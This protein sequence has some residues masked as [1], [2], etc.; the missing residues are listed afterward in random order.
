M[1]LSSSF[2]PLSFPFKPIL[3]RSLAKSG[4]D[5]AMRKEVASIGDSI[6]AKSNQSPPPRRSSLLHESCFSF[7]DKWDSTLPYPM[8]P[9][10]VKYKER[11]LIILVCAG[12]KG[13]GDHAGLIAEE[14]LSAEMTRQARAK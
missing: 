9:V 14:R 5:E 6:S 3:V 11:A 7:S 4:N 13:G 12:R 8:T 2:S 10:I 1:V